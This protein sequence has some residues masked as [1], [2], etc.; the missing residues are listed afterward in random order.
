MGT[1]GIQREKGKKYVITK[2]GKS[3][4]EIFL[5]SI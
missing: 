4:S 3:N 1:I 5:S 2:I